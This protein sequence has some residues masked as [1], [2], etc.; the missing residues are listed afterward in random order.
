MA[1]AKRWI[2]FCVLGVAA[3]VALSTGGH[4]GGSRAA[5]AS[6]VA[7]GSPPG[8]RPPKLP[9]LDRSPGLAPGLIFLGAK[10]LSPSPGEQGGPLIADKHGRPVWFNPLPP[11]QVASDFRVERYRGRPV[12]TW[13]QG[14][15]IGGAGHGE[16]EGVIADTSYHVIAHVHAGDGYKADQHTFRLTPQGTALM[17]AYHETH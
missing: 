11:G 1:W 4:S 12:L 17:T 14:R 8:L 13:W 15:S 6:A 9:V 2:A 16:G 7:A 3:V 10:D 5:S